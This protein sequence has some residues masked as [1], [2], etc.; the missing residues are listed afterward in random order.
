MGE[1]TAER[2][3]RLGPACL[4]RAS[5]R[6]PGTVG[7]QAWAVKRGPSSGQKDPSLSLI[8]SK[9]LKELLVNTQWLLPAA[10][11][12]PPPSLWSREPRIL[13]S[14]CEKT[15]L[16]SL[17]SLH[18][19]PSSHRECPFSER[20]EAGSL[21]PRESRPK[22][23]CLLGAAMPMG[24][25]VC[26]GRLPPPPL[27][28]PQPAMLLTAEMSPWDHCPSSTALA[29]MAP[30]W[31][32]RETDRKQLKV[33]SNSEP[34]DPPPHT[35]QPQNSPSLGPPALSGRLR[36]PSPGRWWLLQWTWR[37]PGS[38]PRS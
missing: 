27:P 37:P 3:L 20:Q 11:H 21:H 16:Q 29:G 33:S 14:S 24:S 12:A 7:R 9:D 2:R 30:T 28:P 8:G 31:R 5:S 26:S 32:G 10:F 6:A 36:R 22:G 17:S 13:V 15:D 34:E 35:Q 25:R 1:S 23:W 19:R 4:P 38:A 18:R